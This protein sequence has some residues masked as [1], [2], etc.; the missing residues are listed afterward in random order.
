MNQPKFVA[1][2]ILGILALI[3]GSSFILM[4]LGLEAFSPFQLA[5]VRLSVACLCLSPF[6]IGH[7]RLVRKEDWKFLALSGLI[8]NGIPA[9]L[10]AVS[11]QEISPGQ[12][13][14]LNSLSPLFTVIISFIFF[15]A[16]FSTLKYLGIILGFSGALLIVSF[17]K[18]GFDFGNNFQYSLLVVIA[19]I[20]YGISA[21]VLKYKLS[22]AS[23]FLVTSVAI[24]FSGIPACFCLFIFTDFPGVLFTHPQGW[25]SLLFTAILGAMGTAFALVLFNYLLKIRDVIFASSVTYLMPVVAVGWDLFFDIKPTF[26]QVS[27]LILILLGV[28]LMSIKKR[29]KEKETIS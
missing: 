7:F 18:N 14:I 24:S 2:F 27:G 23:P 19:T 15:Q 9:I 20:C 22:H 6:L 3:W 25:S 12:A 8:G 21:S 10:F 13:G 11:E 5:C 1:F 29:A 16:R 17:S 4:K 26:L 28:Y